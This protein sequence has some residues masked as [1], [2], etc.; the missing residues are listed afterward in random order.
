MKAWFRE[1]KAN[2]ADDIILHIVGC[3]SD[4]VAEDPTK[5]AIPFEQTV[6][7]LAGEVP[8]ILSSTP[9]YSSPS[10]KRSSLYLL[11]QDEDG[12]WDNCSEVTGK[13]CCQNLRALC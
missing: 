12:P 7:W 11:H 5:R 13:S 8:G 2:C 9:N 1:V 10:S 4:L 6:S 3:K